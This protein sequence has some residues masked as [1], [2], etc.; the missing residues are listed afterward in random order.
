MRSVDELRNVMD[1]RRA[2]DEVD[3]EAV[4]ARGTLREN[5]SPEALPSAVI[6]AALGRAALDTRPLTAAGMGGT[7][8]AD[9]G[10]LIAAGSHAEA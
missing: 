5:A 10:R 7:T 1:L 3:V 8:A 2:R 4:L 6:L 9:G